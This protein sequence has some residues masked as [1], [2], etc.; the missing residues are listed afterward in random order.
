MDFAITPLRIPWSIGKANTM[1][2][3]AFR[4]MLNPSI[5]TVKCPESATNERLGLRKARTK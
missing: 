4:T 3:I 2:A 5:E 1:K